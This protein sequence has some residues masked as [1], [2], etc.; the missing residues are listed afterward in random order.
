MG[1]GLILS[2]ARVQQG[3]PTK[4]A[5]SRWRF[6][7]PGPPTLSF[8]FAPPGSNSSYR[9]SVLDAVATLKLDGAACK[10]R[11]EQKV[12]NLQKVQF[13]TFPQLFRQRVEKV[14]KACGQPGARPFDHREGVEESSR[15]WHGHVSHAPQFSRYARTWVVGRGAPK[16]VETSSRGSSASQLD[17]TRVIVQRSFRP[18]LSL[19]RVRGLCLVLRWAPR[20]GTARSTEHP[21]VRSG[22]VRRG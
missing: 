10:T 2:A 6:R 22:K 14:W 15:T 4:N 17:I 3:S 21:V 16:P 5:P 18:R 19:C 20:A 1:H 8:R 13:S 7:P 9:R 11:L 12:R